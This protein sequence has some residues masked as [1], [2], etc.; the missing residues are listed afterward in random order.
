M[1]CKFAFSPSTVSS[2]P[3]ISPVA[4]QQFTAYVNTTICPTATGE[5]LST[6]PVGKVKGHDVL[7][8]NPLHTVT[9]V[10][11][12]DQR[13]CNVIYADDSYT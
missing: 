5:H 13:K 3:G 1:L 6:S 12:V 7:M 2:S 11:F 4:R 8:C 9:W 10:Y